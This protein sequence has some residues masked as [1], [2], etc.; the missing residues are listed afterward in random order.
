MIYA[1]LV[2]RA[3]YYKYVHTVIFELNDNI[4]VSKIVL[5]I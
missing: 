1:E 5:Q 4:Q 3:A 2:R